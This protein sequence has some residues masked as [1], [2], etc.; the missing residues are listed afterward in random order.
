MRSAGGHKKARR[1]GC[2]RAIL[3]LVRERVQREI[4][5]NDSVIALLSGYDRN[6]SRQGKR[7]HP[8]VA[9]TLSSF[10]AATCAFGAGAAA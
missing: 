3:H 10:G 2:R 8:F 5:D 4:N 6:S 1:Q 7:T 9:G